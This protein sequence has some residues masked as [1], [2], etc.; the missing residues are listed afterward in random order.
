VP[1]PGLYETMLG[2]DLRAGLIDPTGAQLQ[3]LK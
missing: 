2:H 3:A 1:P